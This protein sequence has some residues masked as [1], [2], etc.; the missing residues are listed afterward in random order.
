MERKEGRGGRAGNR[1]GVT[2]KRKVRNNKAEFPVD[3]N[4]P[5]T[6][7]KQYKGPNY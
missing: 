2:G 6:M 3:T 4:R 7:I 5:E 1:E